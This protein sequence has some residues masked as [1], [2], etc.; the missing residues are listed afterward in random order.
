MSDVIQESISMFEM[1][2][3]LDYISIIKDDKIGVVVYL[4]PYFITLLG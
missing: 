3:F 1:D 4:F 2:S